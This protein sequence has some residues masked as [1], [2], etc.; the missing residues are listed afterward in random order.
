MNRNID[1]THAA[2]D[3][4]LSQ[5]SLQDADRRKDEFLAMLA[6]ELRNPLAPIRN[7]LEV[8]RLRKVTDP[9]IAQARDM[10]DRQMFIRCNTETPGAD[11]EIEVDETYT[12]TAMV[13]TI[14]EV[15]TTAVTYTI[16]VNDNAAA[17]TSHGVEVDGEWYV[18][19]AQDRLDAYVAGECP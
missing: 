6:H 12:E 15:E 4:K 8:I 7:A 2:S 5:Q 16:S 10:I 13:P 1:N 11:V 18:F 19:Y 9:V 14:G 3:Q 17:N